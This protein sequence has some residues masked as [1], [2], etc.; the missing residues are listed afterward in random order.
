MEVGLLTLLQSPS[1]LSNIATVVKS[2]RG[3]LEN[4]HSYSAG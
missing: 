4:C 1:E 2:L 3:M